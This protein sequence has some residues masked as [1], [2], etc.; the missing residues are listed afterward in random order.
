[1][2]RKPKSRVQEAIAESA[3]VRAEAFKKINKIHEV[4][5]GD[6]Y[7]NK[8][9]IHNVKENT[10][11]IEVI[12]QERKTFIKASKWVVGVAT[13]LGASWAALGK[14]LNNII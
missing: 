8:G 6:D 14:Y 1:M 11:K 4:L 5:I 3:E 7:G 9:L 13:A 10:E 12:D 2:E